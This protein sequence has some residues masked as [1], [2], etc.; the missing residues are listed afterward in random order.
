MAET[1]EIK[2][3]VFWIGAKDP[4]LRVF[5]DL[6]PTEYGTTYNSYLIKGADKVAIIDT[7]K[8]TYTDEYIEKIKSLVDPA[9][10]DYI[11][12]NHTEPDHSGSLEH[13]LEFCPNAT[14]VSSQAAKTFL[15][16]L[17]HKRFNSHV[18]KDGETIDLGGKTLRFVLAPF[19]HWPDT[20]FTKLE[21]DNIFF[22]CD[23]FGTHFCGKSGIFNDE[24]PDFKKDTFFYFDCIVRPFKDKVLAA[25]EKVRHEVIDC[26]CPSHGPIVRT[27]PWKTIQLYEKWSKQPDGKKKISILFLSPHGNTEKMANAV[28]N[29]ARSVD[30]VEVE[31]H[32]IT[33]LTMDEIRDKMEASNALI[34]GIPTINRDIPPP[35]WNVLA[36]LSGLRLKGNIAAIFGSYGWSGEATK[37]AEERLKSL[38]FKLP[39]PAI[40][41]PFNPRPEILTQCEEMGRS[42]AEELIGK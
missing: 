11:I 10:I 31:L 20:M 8:H 4:E 23:A 21:Q 12:V 32:H 37:M 29:G 17:I 25:I 42:I 13:L 7:V 22:T 35:F 39:V 1:I 5:D 40:R 2:P 3:G 28:A 27:D 6:F 9:N 38:N 30:G 33:H 15:G 24:M 36:S 26:I 14:V 19:L 18:V 41:A 34:F 16:N